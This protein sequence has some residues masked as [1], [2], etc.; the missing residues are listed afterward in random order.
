MFKFAKIWALT[1]DWSLILIPSQHDRRVNIKWLCL[2]LPYFDG[3]VVNERA[4]AETTTWASNTFMHASFVQFA[5]RNTKSY[6][7]PFQKCHLR[8]QR[9]YLGIMRIV[10]IALDLKAK[11]F[12]ENIFPADFIWIKHYEM[13]KIPLPALE[14]EL[15]FGLLTFRI[16]PFISWHHVH[17]YID[18]D[19]NWGRLHLYNTGN[20][21]VEKGDHSPMKPH[22]YFYTVWSIPFLKSVFRDNAYQV[23]HAMFRTITYPTDRLF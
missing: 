18:S 22:K 6:S 1:T 20:I 23:H 13:T 15:S 2:K 3:S 5:N 8:R 12:Q 11:W 19:T 10:W 17:I 16:T 4:S 7:H 9:V 21:I 14:N